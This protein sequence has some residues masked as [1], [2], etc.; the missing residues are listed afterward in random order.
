MQ[1]KVEFGLTAGYNHRYFIGSFAAIALLIVGV[2]G[3]QR[4]LQKHTALSSSLVQPAALTNRQANLWTILLA[5]LVALYAVSLYAQAGL[6]PVGVVVGSMIGGLLG[7]RK[8]TARYP[9][10]P[11]KVL[12]YT[13]SC[14]ACC[15]ST[16]VKKRS[17]ISTKA[18]PRS[19]VSPGRTR[20][21][22]F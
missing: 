6:I 3:C 14:S 2:I 12:S 13:C 20:N 17:L 21:I 9:A 8:T 4:L 10:N 11:Y 19:R 1:Y 5:C 22:P 18:S 16:L 15:T 7:W